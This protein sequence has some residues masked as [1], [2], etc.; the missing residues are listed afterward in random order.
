M[1][2][3]ARKGVNLAAHKKRAAKAWSDREHWTKIYDDAYEFA[4]P[5][6]RSADRHGKADQRVDRLFDNTAIV[7]AF[8]FGGQLQQDLFP[9]GSPF[10]KLAAGPI[11]KASMSEAEVQ[12]M[13]KELEKI[14]DVVSAFFATGEFDTSANEM[15]IELAA[16]TAAL[17]VLEGDERNP[18]RFIELPFDQVAF[19]ITA[20]G[21]VNAVYWKS[22][23]TRSQIQDDFPD[24]TFPAE[25]KA[26]LDQGA[27]EE[28]LINQDFVAD[29]KSGDW[30]FVAWLEDSDH[31][32]TG[33]TY[34]TKPLATPR[35]YRVPG[36]AYGRGPILLALPTIKTLNKA[37]ELTLKA[38]AIQMLGIWGYRPASGFNP[39]TSRLAPGQ[40]WPMSSTGGI[41]GAD[42]TRLDPAAGRIDV[43]QLVT[44]DLRLQVQAALHDDK[45]PDKGATPASATEILARTR[46]VAQNYLGA[47]GRLVHE[48]IPVIVRRTIEIL[49][50]RKLIATDIDIDTLLIK[51][52]VLSPIA[53]ALKAE[54]ITKILEWIEM[55]LAVR[56]PQGL[57]LLC[58]ADAA[59]RHI[60]GRIGVPAEFIMTSDE[61]QDFEAAVARSVQAVMEQ[62]AEAGAAPAAA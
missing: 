6:R 11:A 5:Y 52:E 27:E 48:I 44:Q 23:L 30:R 43:S 50:K 40:F 38:A 32:I 18:I 22:K 19:G 55:I 17:L 13:D 51:I 45:L 34:R 58:K 42:V 49:Y 54:A 20:H 10:F 3:D 12:E 47:F 1:A 14:S 33:E 53:A 21:D 59:L 31:Q 24:G 57:D 7:S 16:G 8:R 29:R 60:G 62:M 2:D 46:R 41:M 25:W 61:Q 36:E 28:V 37:V 4:I 39:D 15:C 26:K 56:G 35:Y 9:P